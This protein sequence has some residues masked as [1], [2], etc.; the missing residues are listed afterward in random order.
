MGLPITLDRIDGVKIVTVRGD[1]GARSAIDEV[2]I[3]SVKPI[4]A[5]E[6]MNCLR[7]IIFL[8]PGIAYEKKRQT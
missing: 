5:A 8:S 1:F 4:P 6:H 3:I 7:F 2:L